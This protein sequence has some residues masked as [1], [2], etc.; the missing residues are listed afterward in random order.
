MISVGASS[1]TLK[2]LPASAL[3]EEA[4]SVFNGLQ[5]FLFAH[6]Q[7]AI[8]NSSKKTRAIQAAAAIKRFSSAKDNASSSIILLHSVIKNRILSTKD[9]LTA[10]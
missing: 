6:H 1:L 3:C 10:S 7:A 4:I 5:I 9:K 8:I 2:S